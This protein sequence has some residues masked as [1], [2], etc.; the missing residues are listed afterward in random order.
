M[1]YW[2]LTTEFPPVHGG[3]ISTY[4]WHTA[5]MLVNNGH[6]VTVFTND[7]NVNKTEREVPI[8]NVTLI[9]FNPNQVEIGKALGVDVRLSL[10]FAFV[11]EQ[12]L[13]VNTAPDFIE[14]QDYMGIGYY[15][16][17]KKLLRYPAFDSLKVIVTI[18]APS[19]L[20]L[21][22]NQ[23]PSYNFPEY[24]IG[25]MEKAS[26]RMADL[27]VSPSNYILTDLESRMKLKD[28]RPIR[29]FNPFENEQSFKDIPT[30][31]Q[32]D[33][34][35]FGKLTP[36]KGCIEMMQYLKRMWD[37]GFDVPITIIGGGNHFFYPLQEDMIVHFKKKYAPEIE[38]G[39][40]LFEGNMEPKKLKS[41]LSRA[42]VI[43]IPSIVDNL[44]YAALETMAMGKVLLA[45]TNSGH[46]E[47]ID[48]RLNGFL[49][50]HSTPASF[51]NELRFILGL[52]PIEINKIGRQAQLDIE[53]QTNYNTVYAQKLIQ[54]K[55]LS[56]AETLS[57][58]PFI[59][60]IEKQIINS[61]LV[62]TIKNKLTVVVPYYNMGKYIEETI[63]SLINI[64][65]SNTE[66][67]IVND[68]STEVASI[69]SLSN[70]E[71]KYDVKIYHKRNEGLSVAR[72]FGA[73]KADGEFLAFLDS[74]DT[75]SPDYY[76]KAIKVL[77]FYKNVSFVGCWAQ[78]FGESTDIWPAF[79]PEPPY[80][81]THN[82]INS[83]ALVYNRQDFMNFGRNDPKMIYGMEDYD[84][85]ISMVKNGARGVSL[86]EILWQYRIRKGSMAQSFNVNKEL[87]L[88][89]MISKKH[90]G[91]FNKYGSEIANI[92][93]HN[94]SGITFDNPTW[95]KTELSK[96]FLNSKVVLLIK[97]SI[98]LRKLAK[99]IYRVINK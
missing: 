75:V 41:R 11:V 94:G 79:N 33:I 51:E 17:Q 95:P 13:K 96:G 31:K 52:T 61:F 20:Y 59:E 81:L 34:V 98:V 37:E 5:K 4:C 39:L 92:L 66:I 69:E 35:F 29:I 99:K 24:W 42:H 9:R 1:N 14:T 10:E 36:Q 6:E 7:Y 54:L 3:G 70:I 18:H 23:V 49:F 47:L 90:F 22:Y 30:F 85:V 19:F 50:N 2:L 44:P 27:L 68:G 76:E 16:L 82:I 93:N 97:K 67:I 89:R 12:E 55:K 88:Y 48:N 64:S 53:K 63:K 73:E 15:I 91:F 60:P 65:Y 46:T 57:V 45:S 8:D 83:S 25:E 40:I 26:I 38:K 72:N 71:K 56:K 74:D 43:I 84:S 62:N 58:F 86:P 77:N 21:E 80:L 28:L 32:K 78:Y 87:Y